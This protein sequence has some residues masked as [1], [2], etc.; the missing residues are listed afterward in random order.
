MVGSGFSLRRTPSATDLRRWRDA[1]HTAPGRVRTRGRPHGGDPAGRRRVARQRQLASV[2]GRRRAP[3]PPAVS[4]T[5]DRGRPHL[6]DPSARPPDGAR[7]FQGSDRGVGLL[8]R[9]RPELADRAVRAMARAKEL[10][11]EHGLL[12][13]PRTIVHGDFASWNVHFDDD[14]KL[15]GVID[16]D[17][18][19]VD[20]RSWEFVIA[21][22]DL[23]PGL[24][25]GYQRATAYPLSGRELGAI[26]PLQVVLQVL[27]V[28]AGLWDGQRSGRFDEAMITRHLVAAGS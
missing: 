12:E 8:R 20:S 3:H 13:L 22:V 9:Q 18:A 15:A 16:F 24:V 21:R 4:R 26:G 6:R 19:H 25:D 28:M 11:S 23:A 10:V 7:E 14:G 2:D 5:P 1:Q 17:L 27:M